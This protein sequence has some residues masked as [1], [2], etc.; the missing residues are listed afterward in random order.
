LSRTET[1][2]QIAGTGIYAAERRR[3]ASGGMQRLHQDSFDPPLGCNGWFCLLVFFLL[4]VTFVG[5]TKMNELGRGDTDHRHC[6]A[7][8]THGVVGTSIKIPL[9]PCHPFFAAAVCVKYGLQI[10]G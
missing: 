5:V 6:T 10:K 3:S 2:V 8:N 1:V 7:P 4:N 9:F